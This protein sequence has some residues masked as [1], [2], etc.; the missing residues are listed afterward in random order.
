LRDGP[1]KKQENEAPLIATQ[2]PHGP[3]SEQGQYLLKTIPAVAQP[4]LIVSAVRTLHL[5]SPVLP[6]PILPSRA[7]DAPD[8][9]VIPSADSSGASRPCPRSR[10][11]TTFPHRSGVRW[12]GRMARQSTH[13]V[14]G[15]WE[16][17][18]SQES[19]LC[20]HRDCVPRFLRRQRVPCRR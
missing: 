6:F 8:A 14:P 10:R 2:A 7:A 20:L 9:P 5:C 18:V 4:V 13:S 16:D 3:H 17:C 1:A 19:A 15:V 11:R 12:R